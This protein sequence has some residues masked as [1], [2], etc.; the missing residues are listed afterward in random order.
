MKKFQKIFFKWKSFF[1]EEKHYFIQS[2]LACILLLVLTPFFPLPDGS[3]GL[4]IPAVGM[5]FFGLRAAEEKSKRAWYD[6]SCVVVWVLEIV[7]L[8]WIKA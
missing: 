6:F 4:A 2:S 1:N 3:W 8:I 5:L 7:I